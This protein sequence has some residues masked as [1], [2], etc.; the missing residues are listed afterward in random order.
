MQTQQDIK[1]DHEDCEG[2]QG[3]RAQRL[4]TSCVVL[5]RGWQAAQS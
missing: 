4:W 3:A 2:K 1:N 5:A